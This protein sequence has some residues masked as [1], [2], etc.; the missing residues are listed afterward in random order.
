MF[1]RV[2]HIAVFVQQGFSVVEQLTRLFFIEN[3][4][5]PK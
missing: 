3:S 5:V 1:S 2:G 4:V